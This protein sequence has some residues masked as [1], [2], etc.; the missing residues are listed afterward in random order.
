M[1][2]G[3][4][5]FREVAEFIHETPATVDD[6]KLVGVVV[7]GGW[8]FGGGDR[9][10]VC[11]EPRGFRRRGHQGFVRRCRGDLLHL[12]FGDGGLVRYRFD[13][14]VEAEV[15]R[16]LHRPF[17]PLGLVVV[18]LVVIEFVV[19]EFVIEFVVEIAVVEVLVEN[20]LVEVGVLLVFVVPVRAGR[21]SGLRRRSQI[22]GQWWWDCGQIVVEFG[23]EIFEEVVAL[24]VGT[25]VRR[26][27]DLSNRDLGNGDLGNGGLKIGGL[28]NSG[29]LIGN[30]GL[31]ER[32]R[33]RL[34][35]VG[36]RSITGL[37]RRGP[38]CA[39]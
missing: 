24:S 18:D 13:R 27:I 1:C 10:A 4:V 21:R 20:C 34:P 14:V 36:S 38:R 3:E 25:Q 29:R 26:R 33:L 11:F 9:G 15:E 6:R 12:V 32:L 7:G 23:V 37:I 31:G 22:L 16:L 19:I 2:F 17:Q 35:V 8:G 30:R 5:V 28:S 39:R